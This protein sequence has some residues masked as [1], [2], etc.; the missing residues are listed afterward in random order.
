MAAA[1]AM[2]GGASARTLTAVARNSGARRKPEEVRVI[3]RVASIAARGYQ[4]RDTLFFM[5]NTYRPAG[6]LKDRCNSEIN[7]AR[8]AILHMIA[9]EGRKLN[10]PDRAR[11]RSALWPTTVQTAKSLG[12][13]PTIDRLTLLPRWPLD[14]HSFNSRFTCGA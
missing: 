1:W 11:L 12:I 9:I 14:R 3:L 6:A 4:W 5:K 2:V 13:S 7:A 8:Y 10:R